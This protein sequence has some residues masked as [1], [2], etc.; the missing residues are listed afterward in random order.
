VKSHGEPGNENGEV[1]IQSSEGGKTQC[2]TNLIKDLHAD[3]HSGKS[4][5]VDSK[6]RRSLEWDFSFIE[7]KSLLRFLR[8]LL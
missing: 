3:H 4:R 2:D 6:A 7:Q 1:K 5:A 8:S